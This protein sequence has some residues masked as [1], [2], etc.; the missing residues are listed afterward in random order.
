MQDGH[1]DK[2]LLGDAACLYRADMASVI[3]AAAP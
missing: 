1:L 3:F 2:R